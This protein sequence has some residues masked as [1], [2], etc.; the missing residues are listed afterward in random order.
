LGLK[1]LNDAVSITQTIQ[2]RVSGYIITNGEDVN[3]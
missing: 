2:R 1:L 3:T